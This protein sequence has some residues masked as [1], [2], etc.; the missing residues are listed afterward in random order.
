MTVQQN[1]FWLET[2][3]SGS[4]ALQSTSASVCVFLCCLFTHPAAEH[5]GTSC[6]VPTTR[7]CVC[8]RS[9]SCNTARCEDADTRCGASHAYFLLEQEKTT[10]SH[11]PTSSSDAGCH[12]YHTT[13]SSSQTCPHRQEMT[14][15][16]L[17][18]RCQ[19]TVRS[20]VKPSHGLN[21]E[22][23]V[24]ITGEEDASVVQSG[25]MEKLC[26]TIILQDL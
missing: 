19:L 4:E 24:D 26:K 8:G 11:D 20:E 2:N 6:S 10:R 9:S 15:S 21:T 22:L 13:N 14:S 7:V 25:N 16:A 1:P 5:G 23:Y 3:D 18:R 12:G 17:P